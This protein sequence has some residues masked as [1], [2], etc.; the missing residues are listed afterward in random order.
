MGRQH[1]KKK[2]WSHNL[3]AGMPALAELYTEMPGQLKTLIMNS[4]SNSFVFYLERISHFLS[5][6]AQKQSLELTISKFLSSLW[7]SGWV[8]AT[9]TLGLAIGEEHCSLLII[10]TIA[11]MIMIVI[12]T[13]EVV[14]LLVLDVRIGRS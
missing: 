10:A 6:Y 2:L 11:I 14:S 12:I 9:P 8:V 13:K 4:S 3:V 5:V 7:K 1:Y